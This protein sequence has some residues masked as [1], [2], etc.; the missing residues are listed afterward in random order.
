[1]NKKRLK[2]TQR[3]FWNQY[4]N[5]DIL[6]RLL[7][8]MEG[9]RQICDEISFFTEGDGT[10]LRYVPLTEVK[11]RAEHIKY[12][13]SEAKKN[14]FG[15][16]VDV[17]NTI[18]HSDDYTGDMKVVQWQTITDIS[19]IQAKV[20]SCPADKEFLEYIREKY[21]MYAKSGADCCWI[22]DDI[23]LAYHTPV[24]CGCFCE[25]CIQ[26]FSERVNK[27]FSRDELVTILNEDT[28]IREAWIQRNHE[29]I[30]KLLQKCAEGI[31][32]GNKHMDIGLMSITL[33]EYLEA[34]I[35]LYKWLKNLSGITGSK[36]WSRPGG[37][38]WSDERP[39]ELLNKLVFASDIASKVPH[40]AGVTYE[41]ENYPYT[42]G[43]KSAFFTGTECLLAILTSKIDGIMFN[44]LDMAGNDFNDY[45]P[46]LDELKCWEMLWEKAAEIVED[47]LPVGWSIVQSG[48]NFKNLKTDGTMI[49]LKT[50]IINGIKKV[51]GW[52]RAGVPLTSFSKESYGFLLSGYAAQTMTRE[53][54]EQLVNKPLIMDA[55]AAE[56]YINLGIG[57]L[58]GVND[59]YAFG[60]G[61]I[62][63]FSNHWLN[64]RYKGYKRAATLDY[65][66]EKSYKLNCSE[67]VQVLSDLIDYQDNIIGTSA[68]LYNGGTAPVA[69]LGHMPWIHLLSPY[70]MEQ[71][72]NI[73][74]FFLGNRI[75][76]KLETQYPI[77]FWTRRN[78]KQNRWIII[79]YNSGFDRAT[80]VKLHLDEGYKAKLLMR[81]DK[82]SSD[83]NILNRFDMKGWEIVVL[84]V[85]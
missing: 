84:S 25:G 45:R 70:K 10:D 33:P 82:D 26:D 23:R 39:N 62:E 67:N 29:V 13:V 36:C 57:T 46:M 83:T 17:L 42:L 32:S 5:K 6:E 9:N 14:G 34:D 80:D 81:T 55:I 43:S 19:G 66:S 31:H 30:F 2:L 61:V 73:S 76:L 58:I 24:V 51:T 40:D 20:C 56:R 77:V 65:F 21:R 50:D 79:L 18:G 68:V 72:R 3:I 47:S 64:G 52:Q 4:C 63:Q 15:V 16:A 54:L 41:I 27:N 12:A 37:G 7:A 1:M 48:G 8:F 22:D 38:F 71:L 74:K 85:I 28:V 69:V 11:K 44:I 59:V 53:E 60:S 75:P 49:D 78:E 35:D